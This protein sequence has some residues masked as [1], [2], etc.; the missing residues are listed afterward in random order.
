MFRLLIF[1]VTLFDIS[2]IN[3]IKNVTRFGIDEKPIMRIDDHMLGIWMLDQDTNKHDYFILE[4]ENDNSFVATYMNR[5]GTNRGWEHG[6]VYFSDIDGT[7]FIHFPNWNNEHRGW[8]LLR[9]NNYTPGS[10]DLSASVVM[11]PNL[12]NMKSSAEVRA[13]LKKNLHNANIYGKELTF[14]Q[15]FVFDSWGS[16]K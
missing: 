12:C 11:D 9:V 10:W 16:S 3:G 13:Y 14:S 7:K 8:M 15:K 4:K 2:G 1:F 6:T 5:G